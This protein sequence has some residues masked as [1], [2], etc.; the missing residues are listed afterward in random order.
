MDSSIRVL[1][2]LALK[3]AVG[4]LAGRYQVESGARIEQVTGID[5]I[6]PIPYALQTPTVFSPAARS[7]P[8][9]LIRATGCCAIW[10]HPKSRR[11]RGSP[12]WSLEFAGP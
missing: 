5:V 1:S 9:C 12:G 7:A 8:N 4:R 10:L 6:G 2:T 11:C 3:G